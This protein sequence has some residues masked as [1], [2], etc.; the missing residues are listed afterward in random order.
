VPV[1]PAG[2]PGGALPVALALHGQGADAGVLAALELPGFLADAVGAGSAPFALAAADGGSGYWHRRRDGEDAQAMLL[3][4]FLPLLHGLA[5]PGGRRLEA[6]AGDRIGLLG[7]SA[8]GYGALLLAQRLGAARVGAVAAVSP[9]LWLRA[10]DAADG[11]FDDAADFAAH[12]VFAGRDRLAGVPVRVDCGWGDP[13]LATAQEFAAGLAPPPQGGWGF[14]GH[15]DA[16]W[17]RTAGDQLRFIAAALSD[18][19][20]SR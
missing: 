20:P 4:E 15:D 1:P 6:G 8:G 16:Y 17:R 14:G 18:R 10:A 9:A 2:G 7:W 13:F 5:G 19:A 3:E 11:A 12:D